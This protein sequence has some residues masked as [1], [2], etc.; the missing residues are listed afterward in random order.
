[1]RCSIIRRVTFYE[2]EIQQI[3]KESEENENRSIIIKYNGDLTNENLFDVL[4]DRMSYKFLKLIPK[5]YDDKIHSIVFGSEVNVEEIENTV[6][7]TLI[8]RKWLNEYLYHKYIFYCPFLNIA[9]VKKISGIR[10]LIRYGQG[11]VFP[12][13]VISRSQDI[14]CW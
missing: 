9:D 11:D 8:G 12:S 6:P 3:L 4:V 14:S 5:E 7:K 1:M 2:L 10:E 13:L